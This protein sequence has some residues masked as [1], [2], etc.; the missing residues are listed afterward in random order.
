MGC[1]QA[2]E[3]RE[4]CGARFGHRCRQGLRVGVANRDHVGAFCMLLHGIHVVLSDAAA[5]KN[6]KAHRA[7][8]NWRAMG[9]HESLSLERKSSVAIVLATAPEDT[10]KGWI[11]RL[12]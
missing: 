9:G 2:A 10:L 3:T 1:K 7:T 6:G 5:A 12:N 11:E 8:G 4:A